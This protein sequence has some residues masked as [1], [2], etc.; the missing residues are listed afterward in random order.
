MNRNAKTKAQ[1]VI[2]K[3]TA[4]EQGSTDVPKHGQYSR[5]SLIP[6]KK[7]AFLK[8]IYM[9]IVF[10]RMKKISVT[11]LVSSNNRTLNF[12]MN[13]TNEFP[14]DNEKPISGYRESGI[15]SGDKLK[16]SR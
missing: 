11:V 5:S 4:K 3:F 1:I 16:K 8:M 15:I 7:D 12:K 14:P 9:R 6:E 2:K 10:R 13:L